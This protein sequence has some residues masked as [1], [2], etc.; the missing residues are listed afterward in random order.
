MGSRP[1]H[2]AL[3]HRSSEWLKYKI[4]ELSQST[5]RLEIEASHADAISEELDRYVSNMHQTR[6]LRDEEIAKLNARF[7]ELAQRVQ[8]GDVSA[9]SDLAFSNVMV[10][11]TLRPKELTKLS[12]PIM[13][14]E[15]SRATEDAMD[16]QSGLLD[17]FKS[18][19]TS[20]V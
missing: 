10:G 16:S 20:W 3:K 15:R 4:A 5:E 2:K 11:S 12:S 13:H 7:W 6:R 9:E 17:S 8:A 19:V 18:A 1:T 14:A